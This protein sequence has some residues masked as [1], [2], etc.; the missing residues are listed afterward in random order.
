MGS[1]FMEPRRAAGYLSTLRAA[2]TVR[3]AGL[4]GPGGRGGLLASIGA[5]GGNGL[6]VPVGSGL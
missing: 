2:V 1:T 4:P 6:M 3:E 5:D